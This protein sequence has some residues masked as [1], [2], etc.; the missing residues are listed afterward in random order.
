MIESSDNAQASL[1]LAEIERLQTDAER[2]L[3]QIRSEEALITW[4]RRNLGRQ[5]I[6]AQLLR[7]VSDLPASTRPQVGRAAN[8]LRQQLETAWTERYAM[9]KRLALQTSLDAPPLDV[10]LPGR[11][12][13]VGRLHP[14]TQVL[15]EMIEA[16]REMGF[17]VMSGREVETDEYNFALLN[18]PPYHPARDLQDTFYVD[19]QATGLPQGTN[20]VLR[21]HTSANQVRVMRRLS[22]PLRVVVPGAC[23]RH[24]NPDPSHGWMFYQMEG[25]AVGRGITLA[26]LKGAISGMARRLFG[27][28]SQLRFRGHYFPY[29]EPSIEADL[30]CTLCA[31]QGCRL[32]S[33]TGWLEIIPGGMIHPQVL[34]NGGIDPT[35][36]TGFAFGAGLDRIAAL[37][38]GIEDIRYLYQ[39]DLQFL[40]QF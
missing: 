2:E 34:R 21:T 36:Y 7:G 32:C 3:A 33:Q 17:Q 20:W 18:I 31:G 5:G 27:P 10:T 4:H 15:R 19:V 11:P 35:R 22:P 37:K 29:T 28:E 38:Y 16:F 14:V 9:V 39:N 26:D 12:R 1:K 30:L 6:V 13:L 40:E 23:Y 25:F 8:R 24:D